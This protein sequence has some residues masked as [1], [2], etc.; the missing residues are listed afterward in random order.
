MES[1]EEGNMLYTTEEDRRL[2]GAWIRMV[3]DPI[4]YS[5]LGMKVADSYQAAIFA[6]HGLRIISIAP[7]YRIQTQRGHGQSPNIRVYGVEQFFMIVSRASTTVLRQGKSKRC[8]GWLRQS[9]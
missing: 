7:V 1:Q 5:L 9:L 2:R 3:H 4:K 6:I 8:E